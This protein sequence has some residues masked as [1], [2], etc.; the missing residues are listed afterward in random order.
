MLSRR[1]DFLLAIAGLSGFFAVALGAL[2]AH[3]LKEMLSARQSL[4][5]WH[6]ASSYQLAHSIA[7][8]SVLLATPRQAA[9]GAA[10]RRIS[11]LWLVGCLLFSGSI[12]AL[13]LDGPRWL[14]PV[15]P[16]GGLA[17]LAG[18]AGVVWLGCKATASDRA[19]D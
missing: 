3:P 11:K 4:D 7:A 8:I 12:Y 17:F 13:A 18:W 10:I 9:T 14:G 6:T 19:N 5:A 1:P 16:L 15:T 2:G